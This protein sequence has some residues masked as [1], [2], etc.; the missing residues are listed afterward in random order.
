MNRQ[1]VKIYNYFYSDFLK[2][3]KDTSFATNEFKSAAIEDI[4]GTLDFDFQTAIRICVHHSAFTQKGVWKA[5]DKKFMKK[6][7]I[8]ASRHMYYPSN[9]R[10][11]VPWFYDVKQDELI[12]VN[13]LF[14][15][16]LINALNK[17]GIYYKSQLRKH[18]SVGWRYLWTL[19]GIGDGARQTIL[20]AIDKKML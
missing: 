2:T 12:E 10:I 9:I 15:K 3:M 18:L 11:A 8:T 14:D 1:N 6:R 7:F 19:P 13:D 20:T 16:R 17:S 5:T 4:L